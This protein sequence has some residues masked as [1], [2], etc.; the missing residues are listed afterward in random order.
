MGGV[1]ELDEEVVFSEVGDG[2]EG[3]WRDIVVSELVAKGVEGLL[4]TGEV[5]EVSGVVDWEGMGE[6]VIKVEGE[7]KKIGLLEDVEEDLIRS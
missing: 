5:G 7:W 1:E 6:V 2:V 4:E 3:W